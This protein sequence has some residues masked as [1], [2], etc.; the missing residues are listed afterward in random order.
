MKVYFNYYD[1][2][3]RAVYLG[4]TDGDG[5]A[6][7]S[8]ADTLEFAIEPVCLIDDGVKHYFD[9]AVEQ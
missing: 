7:E 6:Y 9:L 5:S 3:A 1:L 4:S 2:P 8:L